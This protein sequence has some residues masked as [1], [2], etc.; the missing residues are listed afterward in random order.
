[1]TDQPIP[2]LLTQRTRHKNAEPW[3]LAEV[4]KL[5]ENAHLG[6]RQ[7]AVLLGRSECSVRSQAARLRVSI[8]R[9]GERRGLILGQ[10]RGDSWTGHDIDELR[11]AVT[12][13]LLD[14]NVVEAALARIVA[15]EVPALC[16]RC[17]QREADHRSGVCKVCHLNALTHAHR[18]AIA[19]KEAQQRLWA[20]RQ[21]KSR[22]ARG[23]VVNAVGDEDDEP[24]LFE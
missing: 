23:K 2:D 20:A 19:V 15:G 9:Q 1:M 8:R 3:T 7:V 13:G 10:P 18:D 17:V 14:P 16:P 12:S 6:A 4:A 21:D 11:S 24:S 5:R 22:A